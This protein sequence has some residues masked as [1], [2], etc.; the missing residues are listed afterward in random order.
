MKYQKFNKLPP[1]KRLYIILMSKKSWNGQKVVQDSRSQLCWSLLLHY[2]VFVCV[3]GDKSVC[4]S[5]TPHNGWHAPKLLFL[6]PSLKALGVA[7]LGPFRTG[8]AALTCV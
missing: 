8:S 7:L 1:L 6:E 3:V 4:A 5:G 2:V